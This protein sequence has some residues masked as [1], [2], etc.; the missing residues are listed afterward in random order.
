MS[1]D[2]K[3][4][5]RGRNEWRLTPCSEGENHHDCK[6]GSCGIAPDGSISAAPAGSG[7][8]YSHPNTLAREVSHEFAMP[9]RLHETAMPRFEPQPLPPP[10]FEQKKKEK[11]D[12]TREH[13]LRSDDG[14]RR[15]LFLPTS[16]RARVDEPDW[17]LTADPTTGMAELSSMARMPEEQPLHLLPDEPPLADVTVMHDGAILPPAANLGDDGVLHV[18]AEMPPDPPLFLPPLPEPLPLQDPMRDDDVSR[19]PFAIKPPGSA[20]PLAP[21]EVDPLTHGDPFTPF[22]GFP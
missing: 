2:E 5:C 18:T 3:F 13:V 4:R 14:I 11:D 10:R 21:P 7:K 12:E 15:S 22:G 19:S 6:P 17:R 20:D 16:V 8:V 9:E 1:A